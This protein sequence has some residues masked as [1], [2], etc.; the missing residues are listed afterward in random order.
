M[1]K[2]R[3][4]MMG[5]IDGVCIIP[6]AAEEEVIVLWEKLERRKDSNEKIQEGMGAREAFETYGIM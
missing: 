3:D 6:A 1:V 4:I 2:L 5:D